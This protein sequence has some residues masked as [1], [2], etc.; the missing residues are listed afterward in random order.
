M[1]DQLFIDRIRPLIGNRFRYLG[2][3]WVLI[4]VL[5]D[6]ENLVLA[7]TSQDGPIQTDQYGQALRRGPENLLV[8][9]F[10]DDPESFSEELL[11]VLANK[12]G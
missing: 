6:E 4:E 7:D 3:T 2:Q 8:P 10:G 11:E 12:C 5:A 9:L 1:D